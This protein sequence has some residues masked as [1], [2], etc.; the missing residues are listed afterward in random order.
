MKNIQ[1]PQITLCYQDFGSPKDTCVLLIGGLGTSMTRWTVPFCQQLAQRGFY[2]IRYDHRDTGCSTFTTPAITNP[3]ELMAALQKGKMEP[4]FYSL[5]DLAQDA[6]Q[7]LDQLH[8]EKAHLMGR[9]MGGI[10]AQ[11][12]GGQHKE[13]V[14]SLVIIMSTSLNPTLPQTEATVMQQMMSPL[15][16]YS[17][18]KAE[19][20]AARL[21]FIQR[22]SS[23][24]VPFNTEEEKELIEED[25]N[26]NST[27]NQ[28]LLHVAAVGFTPYNPAIT[29][30]IRCPV[31]VIHGTIDPIFPPEHGLDIHA[32]IPHSK[33]MLIEN[34]GHD[35][36][37]DRYA[38]LLDA[39]TQ[40]QG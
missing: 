8:I 10:V 30:G 28:T 14:L 37:A 26:R 3:G 33:L 12:L 7:L 27:P 5:Y 4:P 19:H 18:A 24:D 1:T 11:I 17:T 16:S 31:L 9:S 22:I 20:L 13:R 34:M 39:F 35:L 15:P 25:F 23:T 36:H 2:V 21:A 32:A 38:L 6:I 40:N 29:A